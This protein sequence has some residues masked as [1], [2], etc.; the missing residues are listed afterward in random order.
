MTALHK[1]T[2]VISAR[3][4]GQWRRRHWVPVPDQVED[5]LCAVTTGLRGGFSSSPTDHSV[6]GI[7][8]V[9]GSTG[10]SRP[11]K[12]AVIPAKAGIQRLATHGMP[13]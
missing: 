7:L 3:A 4:V 1:L 8:G 5:R 12:L 9:N 6:G 10:L 2:T 11:V 13:A